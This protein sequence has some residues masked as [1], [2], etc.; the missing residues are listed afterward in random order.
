V[1]DP[2]GK[3]YTELIEAARRVREQAYVPYSHFSVGAALLAADGRVFTGCNVE[4]ASYGLTLC[5][6]RN[7][8]A[9]AVAQ[10]ARVFEA[11]AVV[12]ENGVSPCGACRQVLSE[13]GAEMLVVMVDQ[14]GKQA[15][16]RI[17]ELLPVA[18][19]PGH[20]SPVME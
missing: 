9:Q 16:Y 18:F 7:A 20:L 1:S 19:G 3:S 6:E 8:L 14:H 15:R 11:I 4:N 12:S 2:L 17:A 5:A 10:G 13:F